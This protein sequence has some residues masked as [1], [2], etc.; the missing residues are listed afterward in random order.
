MYRIHKSVESF[1]MLVVLALFACQ[2]RH[3]LE[4]PLENIGFSTGVADRSV[5]QNAKETKA[6]DAL[7]AFV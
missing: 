5:G 1:F 2:P 4:Q 7:A 3:L 6:Q